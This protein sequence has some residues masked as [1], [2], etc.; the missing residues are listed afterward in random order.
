MDGSTDAIDL[1]VIGDA[2]PDVVVQGMPHDIQYGQV[3]QLVETGCLTIGGSAAIFACAATRLG[4]RTA[5]V[6]V[7]GDDPAGR[8]MLDE[9]RAHDVDVSGCRTVPHVPTGTTVCLVRHGD[10]AILTSQGA[11]L[12]LSEEM[13]GR[14]L[15]RC[16]RHVHVSSF[17]L[18]PNLSRGLRGLL[19]E[20]RA[21]GAGTSLD[22]NWDPSQRWN[23]GVHAA[24]PAVDVLLVN[25]TEALA[26]SGGSQ[27]ETAVATLAA[28]GPMPVI[29]RGADGALAYSKG[30]I[31]R[32]YALPVTVADAIG[33]GDSFNA[34]FLY[35]RLNEWPIERCLALGVA[36]GSLS[37][38]AVGGTTAQPTLAEAVAA[39]E[40]ASGPR[41]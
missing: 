30:R 36:C 3:E 9:L 7:L 6:A 32:T 12:L 13:V 18:L 35:G 1:L 19:D 39:M 24:L 27:I 17:F 41:R 11:I 29:K 14:A 40:A 33:A 21:A 20:A 4:L 38:R 8:F 5:L 34:G 26:L 23:G 25:E 28:Q 16:A 15:L 37:T 22:T 10:R 31:V 2:N